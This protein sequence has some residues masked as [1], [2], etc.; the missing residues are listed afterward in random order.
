[1]PPETMRIKQD[2]SREYGF[3]EEKDALF[4]P[5]V[6][7]EITNVCNLECIHCPYTYISKSKSY[8]PRHMELSI[9]KKV[10]DEVSLHQDV[11]LR[12]VCDGE[13]MMHPGILEMIKYAK[14]LRISPVCLNTNGTL[15]NAR[16]ALSLLKHGIDVIEIS[17]D[18]VHKKT[19]ER[20]RKGADFDSVMSNTHSL[21][22]L[23][24][25]MGLN[26]KIMVSIIDQP[27]AR[28][29]VKEFVDYWS[30]KVDKVIIREYTTIGGLVDSNKKAP[31]DAESRWPCP[32]LWSRI[33]V[34]VD[35]FI[36][37]CVEDWL[38]KTIAG[39]IRK[40]NIA[41]VWQSERYQ[42]L[43]DAHLSN[44]FNGIIHCE[45][46]ADWPARNWN[47]D[48]FHALENI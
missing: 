27:N 4:P 44:K 20:I 41:A 32:L 35:G 9:F 21:I 22:K 38:D 24:N 1:M 48:Y 3:R 25:N 37:Y 31:A 43:R 15:L 2:I 14:E 42:S 11:I 10:I 12:L 47:Y 7:A 45:C 36:K 23:R 29:E 33:F 17:L 26:T 18:A 34:S 6:Y 8:K 28:E 5:M 13:P 46:C 16:A 30:P 39:D 40:D 19:Y